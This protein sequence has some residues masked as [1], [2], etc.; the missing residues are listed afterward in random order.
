[1]DGKYYTEKTLPKLPAK[2]RPEQLANKIFGGYQFFFTSASILSNHHRCMFEVDDITYTSLEQYFLATKATR[3]GDEDKLAK[4]MSLTDPMDIKR[5]CSRVEHFNRQ[6]WEAEAPALIRIGLVAKFDQNPHLLS[7]LLTTGSLILAECSPSDL[8]WGIGLNITSDQLLNL[9]WPGQN[10]MGE[11]LMSVREELRAAKQ[12]KDAETEQANTAG[13]LPIAP[14]APSAAIDV[15][16]A[17][18]EIDRQSDP[19]ETDED[20]DRLSI[21]SGDSASS[22]ASS[23]S[24]IA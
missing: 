16:P 8:L 14:V 23:K 1:V 18:M 3:F 11:L 5:L 10:K 12:N 15:D 22:V 24:S 6:T 13:I 19:E 21:T 4:V 7:K 2:F 17:I 9:P 20:D